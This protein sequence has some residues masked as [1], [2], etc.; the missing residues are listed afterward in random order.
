MRSRAGKHVEQPGGHKAFVPAPLPP[1]PPVIIDGRLW[2]GLSNA[3]RALGRLDG[4]A[5]MLP[6]PNLFVA[7]YV[8]KEAV[9]SSQ[10]EGTQSSL[11]DLLEFESE[12]MAGRMPKDVAEVVNHVR[13][14]NHGLE[15]LKELPLS[16][17]L[18][19]EIHSKLLEGVRGQQ[20]A[21]G[22]F[23]RVQN[24]IGPEG[25]GIEDAMFVPPPP[26]EM[27]GAMAELEVFLH[28]SPPM[29]LLIKCGLV[30]AQFETIHPFLDGNGRIGRLLI[31]FMLCHARVLA[32]PL[33]YISHYFRQRRAEYYDRLQRVRDEGDWEGWLRFFVQGVYDVSVQATE[34]ARRIV[35]LRE[36][37]QTLLRERGRGRVNALGLLDMLYEHPVV[38]ASSVARGL[39]VTEPTAYRLIADM[40]RLGLLTEMTGRTRGRRFCYKPYLEILEA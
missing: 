18:I 32:R 6:N 8:R 12:G 35:A 22:A 19:R 3:D 34:T 10:I 13:A 40:E 38:T 1:D 28:N 37:H 29:P 39:K 11:S 24:W 23:R 9:L 4:L 27:R 17:R 26:Q 25:T 36:G 20:R 7:M 30:H 16:L 31:T 33:L 2:Q 14:M 21:P 5:D 15:R